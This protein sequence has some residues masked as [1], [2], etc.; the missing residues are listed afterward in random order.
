LVHYSTDYVFGGKIDRPWSEDDEP[1]P[2]NYYGESKLAGDMSIIEKCPKHLIF[3]TSWVYASRRANFL[4][5]MLRLFSKS[6]EVRVVDDQVGVPTWARYIAQVTVSALKAVL[7]GGGR[8]VE[9]GI[10]NLAS[11]GMASWYDFAREIREYAGADIREVRLTPIS[12]DEYPT[13]AARPCWSVL[14]TEKLEKTFGIYS[15]PWEESVRLCIDEIKE[16]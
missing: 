8:R 7:D 6:G 15:S 10:Y 5:T 16:G 9:A 3:R 4:R 11:S 13:P 2:L 14:S 1:N 12:S